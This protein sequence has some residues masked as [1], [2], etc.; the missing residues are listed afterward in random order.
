[1][2]VCGQYLRYRKVYE[3]IWKYMEV[4][5]VYPDIL[6]KNPP[7]PSR[8]LSPTLFELIRPYSNLFD[9][10]RPYSILLCLSLSDFAVFCFIL[11]DFA[12]FWFILTLF[13]LIR[14]YLNLIEID[15]DLIRPYSTLF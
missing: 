12:R 7:L 14:F 1:M 3:G 8:S 9:L 5:K 4:Y 11:Y 10:I 13:D 2:K 15:F 6:K